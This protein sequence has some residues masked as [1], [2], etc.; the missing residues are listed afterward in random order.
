MLDD[1][2]DLGAE[3]LA[4]VVG[5]RA[6][7][8]Q[9]AAQQGEPATLPDGEFAVWEPDGILDRTGWQPPA[10]TPDSSAPA[11]SSG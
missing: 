3:V 1:A 10:P 4:S 8:K 2:L 11:E 5:W 6:R 9:R 7:R